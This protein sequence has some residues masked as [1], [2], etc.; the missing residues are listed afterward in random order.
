MTCS[1]QAEHRQETDAGEVLRSGAMIIGG[2]AGG[3]AVLGALLW[4]LA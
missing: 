1:D 3:I 4:L 2:I